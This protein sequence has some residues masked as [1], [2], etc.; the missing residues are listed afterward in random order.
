[1]TMNILRKMRRKAGFTESQVAEYLGISRTDYARHERNDIDKLP[2]EFIGMLA[3]LYHVEEY[4][5]LTGTAV[6]NTY[7]ETPAKE[8]ELIPFFRIVSSFLKMDRLL[9]EAAAA[10]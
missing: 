6:P 10:T 1:M 7:C 9:K 4:D 3:D 8:A 2:F 5:M